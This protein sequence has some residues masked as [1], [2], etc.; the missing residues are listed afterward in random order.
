MLCRCKQSRSIAADVWLGVGPVWKHRSTWAATLPWRVCVCE[1]SRTWKRVCTGL[2]PY[3]GRP[4][5]MI[6]HL[7]SLFVLRRA[8][9]AIAFAILAGGTLEGQLSCTA[10]GRFSWR[11]QASDSPQAS[12]VQA[13]RHHAR[14]PDPCRNTK[15]SILECVNVWLQRKR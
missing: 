4:S 9:G 8:G 15:C 7:C 10:L 2:A 13:F 1:G 11:C 12:P 3:I 5:H 14:T 6:G